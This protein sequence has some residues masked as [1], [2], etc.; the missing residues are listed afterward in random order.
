MASQTYQFTMRTGPAPG[1]VFPLGG[2]EITLG[3]DT[4]N[5]IPLADAE[6]S[7][8]H[9]RLSFQ[10]GYYLLEDLG[11]TNGTFINGRRLNAQ[12][13]LQPGDV[14]MLGENVSLVFE[15]I[16]FDPDATIISTGQLQPARPSP[17]PPG[18]PPISR[19]PTPKPQHQTYT[20]PPPPPPAGYARPQP[21]PQRMQPV[22]EPVRVQP[23]PAYHG[24][25]GEPEEFELEPQTRNKNLPYIV[26]GCGC[27]TVACIVLLAVL[28]YIDANYL[29][30]NVMPFLPG[31]P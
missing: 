20:P 6:V 26:A 25:P 2:G 31:C 16:E 12:Q 11:S 8:R 19:Q 23:M 4:V 9:A 1:K 24:A 22:Q 17:G 10:G 28:W 15:L 3:R 30:C 7:R 27:L 18:A 14:V 5:G 21:V 13:A 29:W